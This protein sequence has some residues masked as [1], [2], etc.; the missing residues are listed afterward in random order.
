MGGVG[1]VV[2]VARLALAVVFATAGAGKLIDQPGSRRAL[3]DFGVPERALPVTSILLPLAELATAIALLFPA[4]ARWG[5]IA[6]VALLL[7]FIAGIGRAL[8]RGEAPDCHCFGQIHSA[9]AGRGT[10]ARNAGLAL[11]AALVVWGAP[12]PSVTGWLS[13][14]VGGELVVLGSAGVALLLALAAM[15]LWRVNR[16]LRRELEAARD[17]LALFPAGLPVG[18]TAPEFSLPSM[19]GEMVTLK[20]LCDRGKPVLLVFTAPKCGP[21]WGL[22]PDLRRWQAT[23]ADS[24]TVAIVSIGGQ[25]ENRE[26]IEEHGIVDGFLEN[27]GEAM[28]AYR[29]RATPSAVLVSPE[30]RVTSQ[31]VEGWHPIEPL[32]RFKLQARSTGAGSPAGQ[33]RVA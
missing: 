28:N 13:D 12:G 17:E 26:V 2:L 5:A 20:S 18:A 22:M 29:V 8:A 9:P 7:A 11:V 31:S 25:G 14:R 15:R 21:C 1:T 24:L 16:G 10:L 4:L 33:R 6:A 23:L 3:A 19:H 27:G 30:G 32:V